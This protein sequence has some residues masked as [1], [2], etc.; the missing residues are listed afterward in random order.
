[1]DKTD[2]VVQYFI[3]NSEIE[4]SKGKIASQ[5]AHTATMIIMDLCLFKNNDDN[6]FLL[7]KWLG[8]GQKKIILRGKLKDLIRLRDEYGFY[9]IIDNGLTELETGTFTVIGLP[10][11]YK[12]KAQKYVKRL[13]LY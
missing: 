9:C 10:P 12:S 6:M 8:N 5:V 1:M 3:V 13:Q 7:G 11:M 2:E 4:M